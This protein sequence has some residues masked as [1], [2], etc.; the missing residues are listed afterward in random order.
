MLDLHRKPTSNPLVMDPD[1]LLGLVPISNL[2]P[3]YLKPLAR[4]MSAE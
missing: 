2:S 4:Y 3:Y 1:E